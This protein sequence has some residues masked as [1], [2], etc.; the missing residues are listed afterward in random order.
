M[1]LLK[2]YPVCL[3]C[4]QTVNEWM[5]WQRPPVSHQIFSS[6][7]RKPCHFLLFELHSRS[8][9]D[10]G[11]FPGETHESSSSNHSKDTN[12]IDMFEWVVGWVTARLNF[13]DTFTILYEDVSQA[14]RF[15]CQ[16]FFLSVFL[17]FYF[18]ILACVKPAILTCTHTYF[19]GSLEAALPSSE[20]WGKTGW[21]KTQMN[22]SPYR[23]HAV[24]QVP[25]AHAE[26]VQ[27]SR[28]LQA[29]PQELHVLLVMHSPEARGWKM[30]SIVTQADVYYKTSQALFEKSGCTH[31]C[32]HNV[33]LDLRTRLKTHMHFPHVYPMSLF[34]PPPCRWWPVRTAGK[35]P[36]CS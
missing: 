22:I 33:T 30:K 25:R 26:S 28:L 21:K 6:G 17:L 11:L 34:C 23:R 4:Q 3:T 7:E 10:I 35:R 32:T 8:E 9:R 18:C 24:T 31:V 14:H 27:C 5:Q 19:R 12:H 13:S 20:P 15:V 29:R 1:R 16:A 2:A 36:P